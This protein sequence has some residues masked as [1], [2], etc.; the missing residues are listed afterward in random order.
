MV[1]KMKRHPNDQSKVYGVHENETILIIGNSAS[2]NGMDFDEFDCF[3]SIGLNRILRVYEPTYLM[4]VDGSVIKAEHKRMK[5]FEGPILIYPGNMGSASKR[6]YDGPWISTGAMTS[7]C[8]PTAKKGP[9][10]ICRRGNSAYEATQIAMRMGASR[11]ALAGVDLYWPPGRDTHFFGSG[12][13]EGC[14]MFKED[15][16]IEDF[17]KL[18]KMYGYMGVEL[19]SVSPW[20]TPLRERLGY[21][22]IEELSNLPQNS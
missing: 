10:H 14:S 5:K 20:E 6:F 11:I 7:D 4:V 22:P 9:I 13:D 19:T 15:L 21:T 18:K 8:D 12:R 1:D 3:T 16:I 2:L 17:H